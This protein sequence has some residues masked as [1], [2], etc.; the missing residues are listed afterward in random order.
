M[1]PPRK[2]ITDAPFRFLFVGQIIE[3]KRLNLL[4]DALS[5]LPREDFELI[6][7]GDGPSSQYLRLWADHALNGRVKWDGQIPMAEVRERMSAADCLVLPSRHDG[8]G[9]VVSEALM[10]GTQ[11][12]CSDR[13]GAAEAVRA[14]GAGG[15]FRSGDTGE[16]SRILQR[17]MAEGRPNPDRRRHLASWAKSLAVSAGAHY[18]ESIFQHSEGDAEVPT[19]PWRAVG[20]NNFGSE[21]N[22]SSSCSIERVRSV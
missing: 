1:V 22:L 13:C 11:A 19:P 2:E 16:L 5:M 4:V 12:V 14:S 3:R 17:L 20:R 8:W 6:V 18:L 21:T 9:A 15:V 7:I 10:A